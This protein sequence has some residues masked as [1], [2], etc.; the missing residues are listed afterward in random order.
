[1]AKIEPL[2]LPMAK[3]KDRI[4]TVQFQ[5]ALRRR[6]R[7]KEQYGRCSTFAEY[8]DFSQRVFGPH[9]LEPEITGFLEFAAKER[10]RTVC[11]IG[12]ANG[13]TTFLLGQALPTTEVLVGVDLF[14]RRRPRLRYFTRPGQRVV[15]VDGDS[16]GEDTIERVRSALGGRPL[17]L[18]L[19]D[20]DHTLA[21]VA[22]DFHSYRPLVRDGGL[23]AFHDIVED[24]FTRTGIR[25]GHWTGDVP[26]FWRTLKNAYQVYEFVV[27]SEQDGLGIGVLRYDRSVTPPG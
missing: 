18:L 1:L 21:G 10:P 6:A 17:D 23:V 25:T 5:L 24:S 3:A 16:G 2:S 26:R 9:Q 12:T 7:L 19:I 15:L 20:G 13:G 27:S 11:E 14:I 8:F 4:E 22:R